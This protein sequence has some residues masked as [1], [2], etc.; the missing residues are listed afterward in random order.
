MW[1]K[2]GQSFNKRWGCDICSKDTRQESSV[3]ICY[4]TLIL[5]H[6]GLWG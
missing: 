6:S 4:S 5:D 3:Q 1:D 2:D